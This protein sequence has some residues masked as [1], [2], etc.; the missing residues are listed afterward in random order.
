M[1]VEG[2]KLQV[3]KF[4]SSKNR[5]LEKKNIYIK[6]FPSD[7]TKEQVEKFIKDN[8]H[9]LG[10]VTSEGVYQKQIGE[11]EKFFAFLAYDD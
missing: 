6:N 7:W 5:T 8:F 11:S 10:N 4:V 3:Q 9:S 1:E 2:K